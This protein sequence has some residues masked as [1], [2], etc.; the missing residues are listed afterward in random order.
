MLAR[1]AVILGA[2]GRD[3]HNFNICFR[4]NP[5]YHVVAFTATQIPFIA[6]RVY[7]PV[8]SGHLYPKGIPIYNEDKLPSLIR[9]HKVQDVFF[10][11]SDVSHE[12]V[13]H[14][15]SITQ[16]AGATFH[17]LG[18]TDTM[19]S[20]NKPVVAV[21]AVRT[22]AGKTTVS[23]LV[24][25]VARKLGVKPVVVRHPM[26]YQRLDAPVRRYE[27]YDDLLKYEATI[28]EREEF[29]AYEKEGVIVFAGIDY[30]AI[31][32]E[33]EKESDI[34]IWDGGNN[35]WSFY[36]PNLNIVVVDPLRAGEEDRYYPGET[37]IRMA[38]IIVVNKVNTASKTDVQKTIEASKRLNPSAEVFKIRSEVKVDRPELVRKKK[39]VVIEDG[40]TLTHGGLKT[41]AGAEAAEHLNATIV[42]PRESA[43]GSI[44]EAY[45]RYPWIGP[46][47]PALGYYSSQLKD[48]ETT[49]N[50]VKCD[51]VLLGTPADLRRLITISKPVARVHFRA[52]D[53]G[54]P[55]L[56]EYLSEKIRRLCE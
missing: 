31:L 44:A 15:A 9:D 41:A 50:T 49:I 56:T 33:A 19:L 26:P 8:L 38:D 10:A 7:P 51:T 3:F 5:D 22:G 18:P 17:L 46:V 24:E 35:D 27:T 14:L 42:D 39:V 6:D 54:K 21:V 16:A 23:H 43:V 55:L 34:I 11:Y 28:E 13:M 47:I 4:D 52:V 45:K 25:E 1:N 30:E 37:N 40:P 29:E 48:L 36:K 32:R 20:T 12:Q 2:A 53:E